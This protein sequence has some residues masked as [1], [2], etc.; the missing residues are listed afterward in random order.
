MEEDAVR[1]AF[2]GKLILGELFCEIIKGNGIAIRILFN[3]KPSDATLW[4]K[5][6]G[7]VSWLHLFQGCFTLND[8]D[9]YKVIIIEKTQRHRDV[10][11]EM[12]VS[13]LLI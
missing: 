8:V 7:I 11:K 3:E 2:P 5:K 12:L 9:F 6:L 1:E 13:I 10:K 4:G